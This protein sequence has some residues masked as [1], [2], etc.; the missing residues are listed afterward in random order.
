MKCLFL[1]VCSISV[2]RI[3]LASVPV[4]EA[5]YRLRRISASASAW[6]DI[7]T[8]VPAAIPYAGYRLHVR[9]IQLLKQRK[10]QYLLRVTAVNTG[11]RVINL[12]PGFPQH[13]L[14]T[15]FD[16]S[17]LQSGLM[18]LAYSLR[19]ALLESRF[20][21]KVAESVSN[22]EFWVRVEKPPAK[23]IARTDK[24]EAK[25][26]EDA[27]RPVVRK[28]A[29][30]PA[31]PIPPAGSVDDRL[32]A[33]TVALPPPPAPPAATTQR[34]PA[35]AL[36][37]AKALP[38][39]DLSTASV[40]V[41]QQQRGSV[42][43]Q[44]ELT[45]LGAA[46]LTAVS[47]G[48]GATIDIFLGGSNQVTNASQ[49]LARVDLSARLGPSLSGGLATGE[50]ITL[51]ERVDVSAA[52]RYTRMIVTQID[53]GQVIAECDETNNEASVLLKE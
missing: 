51:L 26:S 21:L 19:T 2:T 45:N 3:A 17:L 53:P 32:Y 52:T 40:R 7:D 39:L 10:D 43:L 29:A 47:L 18:P 42:M 49:R 1:L 27:V 12:G 9:D 4:D 8:L 15:D 23:V 14:Q 50:T 28:P 24:I 44:I 36:A 31:T 20:S 33:S 16:E 22:L 6:A 13:Y 35:A 38:C 25:A 30:A 34:S 41:A 5:P 48:T 11:A 46:P 37:A